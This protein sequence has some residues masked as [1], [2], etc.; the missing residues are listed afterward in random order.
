[1]ETL[2]WPQHSSVAIKGLHEF[3]CNQA[4]CDVSLIAQDGTTFKA[5]QLLLAINSSFFHWVFHGWRETNETITEFKTS[6][7]AHVLGALLSLIYQGEVKVP[8]LWPWKQKILEAATTLQFT[9]I[10]E[11]LQSADRLLPGSCGGLLVQDRGH[12]ENTSLTGALQEVQIAGQQGMMNVHTAQMR[13]GFSVTDGDVLHGDVRVSS[14][15][16]NPSITRGS[17]V[18]AVQLP[19]QH[20][21]TSHQQSTPSIQLQ[22]VGTVQTSTHDPH[23]TDAVVNQRGSSDIHLLQTL[24]VYTVSQKSASAHNTPITTNPQGPQQTVLLEPQR[25]SQSETLSNNT[26]ASVQT[27]LAVSTGVALSSTGRAGAGSPVPSQPITDGQQG[28]SNYEQVQEQLV[29]NPG[30]DQIRSHI[31]CEE[32]TSDVK[33]SDVSD[34]TTVHS[35]N[36]NETNIYNEFIVPQVTCS[37]VPKQS[38]AIG[39]EEGRNPLQSKEGNGLVDG[40]TSH[41]VVTQN[42]L[43]SGS[44]PDGVEDPLK[45]TE[46]SSQATPR[47]TG[48]VTSKKQVKSCSSVSVTTETNRRQTR[49]KTKL[50]R[51]LPHQF[52]PVYREVEEGS[53]NVT[54]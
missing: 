22:S 10:V 50:K 15:A 28:G 49:S 54:L 21:Q 38:P 27:G 34:P 45:P 52:K 42:T 9:T 12:Q 5:H 53:Q 2:V 37:S 19:Q 4:L 51:L 29:H 39:E 18:C 24:N 3:Y 16:A 35:L 43:Y 20:L 8:S 32:S 48:R 40:D 6:I 31:S 14:E 23:I 44:V 13:S 41:I 1:M 46:C 30:Q 25:T 33:L 11:A 47:K 36:V 7:E 26:Q 17:T